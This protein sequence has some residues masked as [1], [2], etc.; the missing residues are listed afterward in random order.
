MYWELLIAPEMANGKP[1]SLVVHHL[2]LLYKLWVNF[3]LSMEKWRRLIGLVHGDRIATTILF[4]GAQDVSVEDL[5]SNLLCTLHG[6]DIKGGVWL[7]FKAFM[8]PGSGLYQFYRLRGTVPK[9]R[10]RWRLELLEIFFLF[11]GALPKHPHISAWST[12]F[13][14]G[15]LPSSFP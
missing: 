5:L 9:R 11:G 1:Y 13:C 2:T 14:W 12:Y 4:L 10:S 8:I 3:L 7:P 15:L 6:Y